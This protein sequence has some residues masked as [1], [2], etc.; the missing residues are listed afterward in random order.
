MVPEGP[1]A[2]ALPEALPVT[3]RSDFTLAR[4]AVEKTYEWDSQILRNT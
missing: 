4:G 1:I 3:D 2:A